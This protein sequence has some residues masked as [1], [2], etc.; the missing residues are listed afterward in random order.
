VHPLLQLASSLSAMLISLET[1]SCSLR[2]SACSASNFWSTAYPWPALS[3]ICPGVIAR[4]RK[5]ETDRL[6]QQLRQIN[7]QL[8]KQARMESYAPGL[9]YAPVSVASGRPPLPTEP[10]GENGVSHERAELLKRLKTGKKWLREQRP[11][12]ALEEF[13]IALGLARQAQDPVCEK[14]AARGL[15]EKPSAAQVGWTLLVPCG[16]LS[17]A[18]SHGEGPLGFSA[19]FQLLLSCPNANPG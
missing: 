6:N 17:L 8:R 11:A 1:I 19:Q 15:G 4:N 5:D 7:L 3:P 16:R 13:K 18:G 10:A 14:K 2:E 12:L 9:S